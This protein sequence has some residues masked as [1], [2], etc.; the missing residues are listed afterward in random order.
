MRS[1][2]NEV[3][4]GLPV[5]KEYVDMRYTRGALY[6]NVDRKNL[7]KSNLNNIAAHRLYKQMTVRNVNTCRYLAER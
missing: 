1:Y 4:N 6:W 7:G 3:I 2:F 5:K